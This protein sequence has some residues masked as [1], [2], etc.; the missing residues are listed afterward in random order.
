MKRYFGAKTIFAALALA[1]CGGAAAAQYGGT[2]ATASQGATSSAG[3]SGANNAS[4][5]NLNQLLTDGRPGEY[6]TGKVA[7]SSGA[8]PWDPITVT[9]TCNGANRVSTVADGKGI[10]IIAPLSSGAAATKSARRQFGSDTIGCAVTAQFAGY[11]S[12]A[13]T[14]TNRNLQSTPDLGTISLKPA[15]TASSG[16]SSTT[17]AAPKDAVKAFEKA[18]SE[19]LDGKADRAQ[20]D[21]EKAV[22]IYPQFAE[23]WYQLG[24]LQ[25]DAKPADAYNSFTKATAADPKF[26]LPYEHMAVVAAQAQKWDDLASATAHSLELNPQGSAL[27]WYYDALGNYKLGKADRALPSAEKALALDPQHQVLVA[28]QLLAVLLAGKGDNAGALAHLKNLLTYLPAG[29]N[30][31]VVKQQVAQLEKATQTSSN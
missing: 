19:W 27:I 20:K 28:E 12:G 29:P 11:E 18:H 6:F 7:M 13:L 14:I 2:G 24:K 31:D 5:P 9:M 23:A 4:N 3:S 17:A 30:A 10:F 25:Q 22:Q 21:L 8:L 16:L 1:A 15:G 26:A